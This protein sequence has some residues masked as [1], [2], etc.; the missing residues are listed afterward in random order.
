MMRSK[1]R[2]GAEAL[3][4]LRRGRRAGRVS[5]WDRT[6]RNFDWWTIPPGEARVLADLRGPGQITHIWFAQP[7]HFREV[8]LRITWDNTPRPSVMCPVGDFFGLGNGITNSYQSALFS[9]STLYNNTMGYNA[10][11]QPRFIGT[12]LNCYAPMPFRQRAVIELINES[13]EPHPK[14]FYIDYEIFEDGWDDELGYFHAE[15]RRANPF[16][17][18]GGDLAINTEEVNIPCKERFAW[19]N[20][21]VIL[22]TRGRGQYIGCNLSV[23]NLCGGWWGEGDD[24]I[25]VD[26]YKWPPDLHGTGSEDYFNQAWGMQPNAFWRNGSSVFEGHTGG[27]RSVGGYQTCYVFHLENPIYFQREIKVTIEAGHGNHLRN[28]YSSV[29]YWYAAEPTPVQDPPPVRQRRPILRD[30]NG[31]WILDPESQCPGPQVELTQE[32]LDASPDVAAALRDIQVEWD[33]STKSPETELSQVATLLAGETPRVATANDEPLAEFRFALCGDRLAVLADVRDRTRRLV[34]PNFWEGS[35][36][37]IFAAPNQNTLP[38]QIVFLPS[39]GQKARGE[40][41]LYRQA[42]R[43]PDPTDVQWQA[44]ERENGYRLEA[45]IPLQTLGIQPSAN[46][47]RIEAVAN[48]PGADGTVRRAGLVT[49][50]TQAW[51]SARRFARAILKVERK[52]L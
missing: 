8:L 16:G 14:W 2:H 44:R 43:L 46:E 17:G 10:K 30:S 51:T 28:D 35:S 48:V 25:W 23:A 18:W 41:R 11:G 40:V 24:M 49:T 31:V 22:D 29:A 37:E 15:F 36:V 21:Y 26:G 5:S 38:H 4:W 3:A 9:A 47:F 19:G 33:L 42:N 50:A 13:D 7:M 1:Y 20:N 32:I 27:Y 12:A 45:L 52:Q 34:E 39:C 6:G